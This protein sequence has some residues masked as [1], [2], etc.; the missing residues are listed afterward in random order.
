MCAAASS[1]P[2]H[3]N[4]STPSKPVAHAA[5]PPARRAAGYF[6]LHYAHLYRRHLQRLV[7]AWRAG[8]L[9][10]ALDPAPF[11]CA[12]PSLSGLA[13]RT[14]MPDARSGLPVCAERAA[15]DVV[16]IWSA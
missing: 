14:R 9:H 12:P 4:A 16:C 8:R 5:E 2:R 6:L 7:A 15:C 1:L 11:R 10:V 3:A 13:W